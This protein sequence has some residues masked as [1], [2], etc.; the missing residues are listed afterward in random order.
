MEQS[1][2][3]F[4]LSPIVQAIF[5]VNVAI[6]PTVSH[7][8]PDQRAI[9]DLIVNLVKKDDVPV[10]LRTG[11]VLVRVSDLEQ[12]GLQGFAGRRETLGEDIYV[13][14]TS[15]AP[16]VSYDL[17]EENF[18]LRLTVQPAYL[19]STVLDLLPN[20][21]P[22]DIHYSKDTSLFVNYALSLQDF[23][24]YSLFSELGLSV[25]GNLLYS[26]L[27]R[28]SD[29]KI[30]RS[31]S[32]FTLDNPKSLSRWV[33]GDRFASTGE[34]GGGSFIGGVSFSREF[35]LDPYFV[36]SPTIGVSGAVLTPSTVDVYVNNTLARREQLPP[37]PF[38]LRNLPV[39]TGSGSARLVIRDAFG[40][41]QQFNYPYYYS[42]NFLPPGLSEFSYSLGFRRNN[43]STASWDYGSLAFLGQHRFGLTDK[44][45][46]GF[47]LEAS[48]DIVSG[49]STIAARLPFG[50]V[51]LTAAASS[52]EGLQGAAASLSYTYSGKQVG[53]G[54]AARALSSHYANLSLK[55]T[56]D[57]AQLELSAFTSLQ[58][59]PQVSLFGRYAYSGWRDKEPTEQI[60]L[61]STVRL[62]QQA[63]LFLS[64]NR[65]RSQ[66][67]D[68]TTE[69]FAGLSYSF[70]NG[71]T[72]NLSQRKQGDRSTST[73][74]IQKPLPVASGFGYRLQ[75]Q[76]SDQQ[77]STS[78][79]LRYQGPYGL[80]ELNADRVNGQNFT[81]FNAS[82]GIVA[83]GGKVLLT[84]PVQ[85]SFALI[86]VP[87]VKGV[88]SYL[89]NQEIGRT[90]SNGNL[91]IPNLLPYYGNRVGI[92][93]EDI[94]TDYS[95]AATER[96]IAPPYRGGA[97]VR[98]PVQQTQA[99]TGNL[100]VE[101]AGKT[102][103]PAYGQLNAVVKGQQIFS[104]IGGQGEFYLENLP[105][106][107][108]SAQVEYRDG[109]CKFNVDV[110]SSKEPFFKLGTLRCVVP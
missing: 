76:L 47:R 45:T 52:A 109:I 97:V 75:G 84:R 63:N 91:L 33:I 82:G 25:G 34:L 86:Q 78:S 85:D 89:N 79:V 101:V 87:R 49:G 28:N 80:Y 44:L 64:A 62:S 66:G 36:R 16:A 104:P 2:R 8:A 70:G 20:N 6:L 38:Q 32:N 98:F 35:N 17:D 105:A 13:S 100:L 77:N 60:S 81:T 24:Q 68:T 71:T 55:P 110:P 11:D 58:L 69:L 106:G 4:L 54:V 26:S 48:S 12:A 29:G 57:R 65:S 90:G 107:K 102:V 46:T 19:S 27:T 99:F 51:G 92:S 1:F 50:E 56:D 93:A 103:I 31:L 5:I 10:L 21:R 37:G 41:E 14:L 18:A 72:V 108:Y 43:I 7:A 94:P 23:K 88:H 83:I 22:P 61:E 53:F 39:S 73:F 9:F 15:L 40:R 96:T 59:S 42:T 74:Q 3:P 30:T 95:I 67:S